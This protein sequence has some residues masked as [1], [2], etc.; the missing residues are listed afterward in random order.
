LSEGGVS[1]QGTYDDL[2][3][4]EGIFYNLA[5]KQEEYKALD[6]AH[7]HKST[8]KS[9]AHNTEA[10][11][12]SASPAHLCQDVDLPTSA[13]EVQMAHA[14]TH[15]D[16]LAAH[17]DEKV[18]TMPVEADPPMLP[19][20]KRLLGIQKD[21][22][23]NLVL[24][25][26]FSVAVCIC[27]SVAFYQMTAV[28]TVLYD[29]SPDNMRDDAVRISSLLGYMAAATIVGFG[30]SGW[31]NGLAGSALTAKLRAQGMAALMKQDMAF[32][33]KEE[34]LR[35]ISLLSWQRRWIRCRR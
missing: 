20:I 32:F 3:C 6:Q 10:I 12:L 8:A 7:A 22:S 13:H 1:E 9:T 27:P 31:F 26:L 23:H 17:V 15:G 2:M 35:P 14:A 30:I 28:M 25:C 5:K 18:T 21:N 24:M 29:P 33:D 19:A 16:T 34:N 11:M 4:K